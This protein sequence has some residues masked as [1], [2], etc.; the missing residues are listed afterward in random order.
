MSSWSHAYR[1]KRTSL[2][3]AVA[4]VGPGETIYLGG[5]AATPRT[6]GAALARRGEAIRG[7]RIAHVLLIGEDPFAAAAAA[8]HVRHLSWFVGPA[9]RSAIARPADGLHR[10]LDRGQREEPA[11]GR[12]QAYEITGQLIGTGAFQ[13]RRHG[14]AGIGPA[15]HRIADQPLKV[16][17][18]RYHRVQ[19]PQIVCDLIQF[20]LLV[21]QF[22]QS[23]RVAGG[24]SRIAC[25][26][27][28]PGITPDLLRNPPPK[29]GSS[30][31]PD[32]PRHVIWPRRRAV[33]STCTKGAQADSPGAKS[34]GIHQ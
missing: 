22:K 17:V 1:S 7:S 3:Q 23:Q 5:N 33:F 30:L 34:R 21:C 24:N 31:L 12:N 9:D 13:N 25:F 15:H 18:V 11:I 8:G 14:P 2:E 29:R 16:V 10:F 6:L 19:G 32:A 27:C 4:A 20:A 28:Q 26:R